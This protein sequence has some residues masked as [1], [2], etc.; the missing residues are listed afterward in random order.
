MGEKGMAKMTCQ[1]P[2]VL[3]GAW[4]GEL[5]GWRPRDSSCLRAGGQQLSWRVWAAPWCSL[6]CS[7][8]EN[9]PSCRSVRGGTVCL[10]SHFGVCAVVHGTGRCGRGL[11]MSPVAMCLL[12][13]SNCMAGKG[14]PW[15]MP[16]AKLQICTQTTPWSQD[17]VFYEQYYILME[18]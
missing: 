5:L 4:G 9:Q 10:G 7:P 11:R 1:R 12:P 13:R 18:Q 2:A 6:L 14:D 8:M 15:F 17:W 3:S 16:C